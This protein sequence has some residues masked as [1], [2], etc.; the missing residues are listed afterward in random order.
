MTTTALST[1]LDSLVAVGE[2]A[3]LDPLTV[4]QE[5]AAFAAAIAE[6]ARGAFVDWSA[7]MGTTGAEPFF[8]AATAGRRFRTSPTVYMAQLGRSNPAAAARYADALTSVA[9]A[10]CLLGEAHPQVAGNAAT[11][12]NAQRS[13]LPGV[14]VSAPMPTPG[15]PQPPA[16]G[17]SNP[18]AASAPQEPGRTPPSTPQPGGSERPTVPEPQR[19]ED[20]TWLDA[21]ADRSRDAADAMSEFTKRAPGILSGVFDQLRHNQ[22]RMNDLGMPTQDTSVLDANPFDLSGIDPHAPGR[23]GP[24]TGSGAGFQPGSPLPSGQVPAGPVPSGPAPSGATPGAVPTLPGQTP[25]AGQPPVAA[26]AGAPATEPQV[27]E[28]PVRSLDDLLAE[29]DELIGLSRV[30]TEIHKQ[31]AILKVQGLRSKAGLKDP[32]ITRHLV[33]VGNPGTGKTTVARLVAGIYR[34]LGLLSKGQLIEVDRS[35]L[36]AGYLGQTAIKTAEVAAKAKGGVLFIDEAYALSGDQYGEEAINTLVKEMEDNRHDL[37]VI[38]AGYPRPMSTFIAENPGLSSRFRTTI[39]FDDYTDDEVRAIFTQMANKA[40]YDV[41]PDALT[42]FSLLLAGQVRDETFGN[43]RFARNTFEA[44]IGRHAWRIK[45]LADPT[46]EQL[47]TLLP[48]DVAAAA[49]GD[50]VEWP[51]VAAPS[52]APHGDTAPDGASSPAG[53]PADAGTGPHDTATGVTPQATRSPA[54]VTTAAPGTPGEAAPLPVEPTA[55]AA[56]DADE[57]TEPA[58][59]GADEADSAAP[60]T[61]PGTVADGSGAHDSAHSPD[62]GTDGGTR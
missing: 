5:G 1:A 3:G 44:S 18:W 4:R 48:Q 34:A 26:Q 36:V 42:T 14:Q 24:L 40:D 37:V 28:E 59:A 41:S 6:P 52:T 30:K 45:D 21:M 58:A 51:D 47:R 49:D 8:A 50:A 23:F 7:A 16:A 9:S 46:L 17:P 31:A 19:A 54:D 29:L 11:A 60:S 35:E 27:P 56:A 12:L 57:P 20:P 2:A 55:A 22:Q 33:F 62:D 38:V 15:A 61:G 10:A 32:T 13:A 25:A 39:E 53:G 43:G